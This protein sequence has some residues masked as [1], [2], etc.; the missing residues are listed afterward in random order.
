MLA[1][2]S[3]VAVAQQKTKVLGKSCS[4]AFHGYQPDITYYS[5]CPVT[6]VNIWQCK[7][8]YLCKTD[9]YTPG[10]QTKQVSAQ[11]TS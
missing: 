3:C 1:I 7:I 4:V 8:T 6:V 10:F 9:Y 11:S 2:H 5:V